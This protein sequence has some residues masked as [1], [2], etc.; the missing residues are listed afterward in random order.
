MQDY[1]VD[2][3]L[4]MR[5]AM[6]S[7]LRSFFQRFP[8]TEGEQATIRALFC[9]LVAAAYMYSLP[10]LKL[11]GSTDVGRSPD[12]VTISPDGKAYVANAGSNNVSVVDVKAMKEIT[13]IP[14]GQVP[15]RN[16]TA[17]LP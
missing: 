11:L 8:D 7:K 9:P 6:P 4:N 5:L 2:I 1:G 15:K 3:G 10:D 12:W 13:R 16:I 14:V 17:M